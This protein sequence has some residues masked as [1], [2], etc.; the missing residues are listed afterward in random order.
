MERQQVTACQLGL[1]TVAGKDSVHPYGESAV[2]GLTHQ[3]RA[4]DRLNV[5]RRFAIW[6]AATGGNQLESLSNPSIAKKR[7]ECFKDKVRSITKRNKDLTFEQIIAE[8]EPV[9]RDWLNCFGYAR[10]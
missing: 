6:Y 1:S 2:M 10:C 7:I 8:L 5:C 9:M 3:R 4:S